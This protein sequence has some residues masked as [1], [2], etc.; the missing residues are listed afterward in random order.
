MEPT[1]IERYYKSHNVYDGENT[2]VLDM[3][4]VGFVSAVVAIGILGVVIIIA[5]WGGILT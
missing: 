1:L 3:L 4:K 5:L 2:S